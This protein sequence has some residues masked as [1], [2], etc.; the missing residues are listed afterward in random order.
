MVG[1]TKSVVH[2]A[3][4]TTRGL[5]VNTSRKALS[6]SPFS[7]DWECSVR[8]MQPANLILLLAGFAST[9]DSVLPENLSLWDRVAA[10]KWLMP[11]VAQFRWRPQTHHAL[12]LQRGSGSVSALTVS[13]HSRGAWSSTFCGMSTSAVR[14]H[15]VLVQNSPLRCCLFEFV[16]CA[17]PQLP[18]V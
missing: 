3:M 13:P 4:P 15:N 1:P 5:C 14:H 10:L 7:T 8:V 6:S 11:H 9:G 12:G 16:T 18:Y 17:C 2:D